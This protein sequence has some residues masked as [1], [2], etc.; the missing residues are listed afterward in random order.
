MIQDDN[1]IV[2]ATKVNPKS[3]KGS[4]S[5]LP[6][7]VETVTLSFNKSETTEESKLFFRSCQRILRILL[8]LFLSCLPARKRL[9]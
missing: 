6:I 1:V 4:T 8:L 5:R 3:R 9:C 7:P 2:W